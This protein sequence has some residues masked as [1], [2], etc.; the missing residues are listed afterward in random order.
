MAA[1]AY[2]LI[3]SMGIYLL[4]ALLLIFTDSIKEAL[5][6]TG[7]MGVEELRGDDRNPPDLTG[8]SASDG[9][10]LR[11][12]HCPL[13]SDNLL[14]LLYGSGYHSRYLMPLSCFIAGKGLASV[15]TPDLRGHHGCG[16]Q[17]GYQLY[18]AIRG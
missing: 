4:I 6:E 16:F 15:V 10:I 3:G 11:F 17:G 8:Y 18:R 7:H 5:D 1:A 9:R 12:R 2:F 13:A 14:V